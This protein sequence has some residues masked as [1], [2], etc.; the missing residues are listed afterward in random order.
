MPCRRWAAFRARR[1]PWSAPAKATAR[2]QFETFCSR[3]FGP[4]TQRVFEV[5]E[6]ADMHCQV[7]NLPRSNAVVYDWLEETL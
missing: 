5:A 1:W 4:V 3:M 7:G 2:Q 6:G